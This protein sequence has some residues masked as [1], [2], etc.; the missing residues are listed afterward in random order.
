MI[1]IEYLER[2]KTELVADHVRRCGLT[3]L[4][5][6]EE[7]VIADLNYQIKSLKNMQK[8]GKNDCI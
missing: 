7:I 8:G 2:K 1:D 6:A 4:S 5:E 3:P